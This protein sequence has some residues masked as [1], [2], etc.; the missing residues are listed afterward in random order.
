[1]SALTGAESCIQTR[2]LMMTLI[3]M[4]FAFK[5]FFQS[6]KPMPTMTSIKSSPKKLLPMTH[7]GNIHNPQS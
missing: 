3:T 6:L 4:A 2:L 1:M 7:T 5:V